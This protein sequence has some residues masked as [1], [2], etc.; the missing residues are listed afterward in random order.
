MGRKDL[1]KHVS[2]RVTPQT[3]PV[4]GKE[5]IKSVGG[6][7]VFKLDP[8]KQLER[9]ILL[10]SSD[11]TYY[12]GERELTQENA[13]VVRACLALDPM[14]TVST[15]VAVSTSGRAP[16]NEPAI[17]ALAIAMKTTGYKGFENAR[18]LANQAVPQVCRIGTHLFHLAD[19]VQALGG[20]GPATRWAFANWYLS[21][22]V[23]DLA[24]QLIK[25]QQRDGWSHRDLLCKSHPNPTR[26]AKKLGGEKEN[27]DGAER[28][29]AL[30]GWVMDGKEPGVVHPQIAAFDEAKR[31]TKKEDLKR[32]CDLVVGHRLPHECVPNEQKSHTELWEALVPSMGL[33]ALVRNLAK[34]SSIGVLS[35]LGN[36]VGSTQAKILAKLVDASELRRQRV[37]PMSL[38]IALNQYQQGHGDKGKLSWTPVPSV[39]EALNDAF[40]LAFEA[41]VPSG[42]ATLAA[43][44]ISHSMSAGISAAPNL[45]CCAAAT[46]MGML[47]LRT[48]PN[49]MALGFSDCVFGLTFGRSTRLDEAMRETTKRNGA[50]TDCSLPMRWALENKAKAEVFWVLTD[51]ASW[52]GQI[53]PFQQLVQYREKT[54][55][56]AKMI[57]VSMVS[58]A[59]TIADPADAGSMDVVGFDA[60]VPPVMADFAR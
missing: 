20:W 60:A 4:P 1:A 9:F 43:I 42:K 46:A 24:F 31:L 27:H 18:F 19:Y 28:L 41:V 22:P 33:T 54:G 55:I 11:G 53:H 56:A 15:I 17:L 5:Q 13:A 35:P 29:D 45:S 7:Y 25:Y 8:W 49:A 16:K 6:G 21:K 12:V 10:G 40:Y 34:L 23:D 32:L 59:E 57:V 30:L 48:E 2:T 26:W 36:V 14:R 3:Q 37:H 47:A 52:S 58:T 38:L 51:S 39:V 50:G 44:D